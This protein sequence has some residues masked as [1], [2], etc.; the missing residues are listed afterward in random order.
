MKATDQIRAHFWDK[1]EATIQDVKLER[2][3]MKNGVYTKVI[4]KV[5]Y[6]YN[7]ISYYKV[8]DNSEIDWIRGASPETIVTKKYPIKGDLLIY[9]NPG[10][11]SEMHSEEYVKSTG[12]LIALCFSFFLIFCGYIW[13]YVI[14]EP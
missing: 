2:T 5:N 1:G 11:L 8:L 14:R 7:G 4:L 12:S 3:Y 10:R 9:I 13:L 6:N